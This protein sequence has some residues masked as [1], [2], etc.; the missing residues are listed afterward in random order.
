MLI[1]K[2]N[3]M[4]K[5]ILIF[6]FIIS[7]INMNAQFLP[8]STLQER[9]QMVENTMLADEM[10]SFGFSSEDI[11]SSYSLEKYC[12]VSHQK[13]SSCTGHAIAGALN[14][15]Y[16]QINNITRYTEQLVNRFDPLFI[17]CSVKD[18]NDLTCIDGDGCAC[19][20][21][22][23]EGLEFVMDHGCKKRALDPWLKCGVT[24]NSGHHAKM[25]YITRP[26]SMD[27]VI[28]YVKW[29]K[30]NGE[31]T[32]RYKMN[33]DYMREAISLGFPLVTGI[34]TPDSF[35]D[36]V[37]VYSPAKGEEG[38][39]AVTLIGYDD[40]YNGGS[41]RVL[42]SYG[43]DW[44]DDGF[45][46]ISYEDLV[47][48]LAC[49]G[50][51]LLYNEDLDYSSWEDPIKLDYFYKG[52]LTDGKHWEGPMNKDYYCDGTGILVGDDFSAIASYK[53][54]TANGWWVYYGDAED[55]FWGAVLYEDGEYVESES[56][57]FISEEENLF[58]SNN[59]QDVKLSTSKPDD[60]TV[61]KLEGFND[62]VV[63]VMKKSKFILPLI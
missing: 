34:F 60:D 2:Q 59:T 50:V 30:K 62:A 9:A 12:V 49:G 11:P 61:D 21:F 41:F 42:N 38:P 22:I 53:D 8:Q 17:Y 13:G 58:I 40:N 5:H 54:G 1:L 48:N 19:G 23:I 57:G 25:D 35:D 39:H 32:G 18:P 4:K 24:L 28:N 36:L 26:Y 43:T 20:T 27:G 55:D 31:Y 63:P 16:N 10:E 33:I 37:S 52:E 15:M 44:G 6:L 3:S 56:W 14:I 29:E 7:V 45:F 47:S 51:Y 46:W